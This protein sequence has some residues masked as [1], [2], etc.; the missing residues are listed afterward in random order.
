MTVKNLFKSLLK[1]YSPLYRLY[2][3]LRY[4]REVNVVPDWV[5]LGLTLLS[6]KELNTFIFEQEN[7]FIR[8]IYDCEFL[9]I[10]DM[11]GGLLGA[12]YRNGFELFEIEFLRKTLPKKAIIFDVGANFGF[13]SIHLAK[14]LPQTDIH[15]FEPV[16]KVF[17]ILEENVSRNSLISKLNLNNFALGAVGGEVKMTSDRYAGNYVI[18]KGH[19]AGDTGIVRL[20]TVD[21]YIEQKEIDTVDFIKCDVEGF[22]VEVMSGCEKTLKHLRPLVMVEI[23]EEWQKRTDADP[24]LLFEQ[25]TRHNYW[26]CSSKEL[27]LIHAFEHQ[28]SGSY[29][30]FFFP[31]ESKRYAQIKSKL[32]KL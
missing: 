4:G 13:Y 2:K 1:K 9:Y 12:E 30:F 18:A 8:T 20:E 17:S 26:W 25:M 28:P 16:E 10:P 7:A 11:M 23:A 31:Q 24:S 22:E 5:S 3:T 14:L 19:Y 6:K 21:A 15:S 27:F 32:Q 29:N